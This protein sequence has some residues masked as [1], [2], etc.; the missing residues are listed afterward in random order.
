MTTLFCG[1]AG[2]RTPV[3]REDHQNFYINSLL[4]F[5][6]L[7]MS[8]A[9]SA[10]ISYLSLISLQYPESLLKLSRLSRHPIVIHR[11]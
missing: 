1:D 11:A 4:T 10:I 2:N 6:S 9:D 7:M 3:R 8:G 5:I